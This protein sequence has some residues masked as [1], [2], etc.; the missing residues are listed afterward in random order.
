MNQIRYVFFDLDRT[1]WDFE[2]CSHETL[3]E[4]FAE[5]HP[6]IGLEHDFDYFLR[7]YRVKNAAL[8]KAFEQR[9]IES[10]ELRRL[11]W[12]HT[13]GEM[14]VATDRWTVR[15]G[16]EYID[17]CPRKT[18][19]MPHAKE[20]LNYLNA[21]YEVHMITNG[22]KDTQFNKLAHSGIQDYFGEV[23]TSDTAGARKPEREI[24]DYATRQV[25]ARPEECLY[26]GDNYE[27]DA[28]GGKKAGWEVVFYNPLR[29][30][31]PDQFHEIQR[32]NELEGLL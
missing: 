17:R 20:V 25:G 32:L 27:S 12:E 3:A 26:V 18:Y 23:I 4:L 10:E 31:N 28:V 22:W 6:F 5:Y 7:I 24:F 9:K 30:P 19:L 15:M 11:R 13:F 21:D 16:E 2:R 8:W 14:Q 1:L 29:H